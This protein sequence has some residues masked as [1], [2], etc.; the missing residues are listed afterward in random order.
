MRFRSI[1]L[2]AGSLR[3]RLTTLCLACVTV[4]V[5]ACAHKPAKANTYAIQHAYTDSVE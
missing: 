2:S 4:V 1:R 5:V 3:S